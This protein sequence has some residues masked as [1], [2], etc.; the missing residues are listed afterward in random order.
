MRA[1]TVELETRPHWSAPVGLRLMAPGRG[2]AGM[3]PSAA[4]S[5]HR[6][7]TGAV[8]RLSPTTPTPPDRDILNWT[9]APALD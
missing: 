5:Y 4:M 3:L 9:Y 7:V 2:P 8:T 6:P 1:S